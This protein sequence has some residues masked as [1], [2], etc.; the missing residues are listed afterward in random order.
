MEK[1]IAVSVKIASIIF[2]GMFKV[3][4][5]ISYPFEKLKWGSL[6]A[7]V[8]IKTLDPYHPANIQTKR[9]KNRRKEIQKI[10]TSP[11][12]PDGYGGTKAQGIPF[13]RFKPKKSGRTNVSYVYVSSADGEFSK[14]E[15]SA[16]APTPTFDYSTPGIL[17]RVKDGGEGDEIAEKIYD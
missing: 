6:Q 5:W 3:F 2:L 14:V 11:P 17:T 10:I 13:S 7:S 15:E 12:I 1:T 4:T 16:P 8:K 9:L